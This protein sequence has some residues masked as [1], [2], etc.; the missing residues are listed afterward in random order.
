MKQPPNLAVTL[1][2]AAVAF[3]AMLF[4]R[5]VVTPAR[6]ETWWLTDE[7]VAFARARAR[8]KPVLVDYQATWSVPS[9]EMSSSLE[10][11]RPHLEGAFI[12]LRVDVSDEPFE[13]PGI[14][15]VDTDGK[16]LAR[17]KHMAGTDEIRRTAEAVIRKRRR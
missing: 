17:I 2:V 4:V 11:L 1:G 10:E 6:P 16:V 14:A 15:F 13:Q 9:M 8:N 5:Q 7:A 3:A 12:P